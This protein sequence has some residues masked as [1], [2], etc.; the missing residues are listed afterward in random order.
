V[1][2]ARGDVDKKRT[3][4]GLQKGSHGVS[5]KGKKRGEKVSIEGPFGFGGKCLKQSKKNAGRGKTDVIL[6]KGRLTV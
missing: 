4:E 5:K 1:L 3:D 2:A 6:N